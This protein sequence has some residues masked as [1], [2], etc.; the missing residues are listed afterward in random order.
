MDGIYRFNDLSS[1]CKKNIGTVC[2]LANQSTVFEIWTNQRAGYGSRDRLDRVGI[3]EVWDRVWV[4]VPR[5][6]HGTEAERK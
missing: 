2:G 6:Q 3:L 5:G 4:R 1:G